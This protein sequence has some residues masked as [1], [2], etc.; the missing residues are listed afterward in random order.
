MSVGVC[1]DPPGTGQQ[2]AAAPERPGA[3]EQGHNEK[4]DAS[5]VAWMPERVKGRLGLEGLV[6]PPGQVQA[7]AMDARVPSHPPV[8]ASNA[9]QHFSPAP[10]DQASA[11]TP[12]ALPFRVT[13]AATVQP[14]HPATANTMARS[15]IAASATTSRNHTGKL[16]AKA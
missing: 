10:K 3:L 2:R 6:A 9:V 16:T 8:Y 15:D 7:S 14:N 4:G 12:T 5:Q 13:A 11:I 1:Q